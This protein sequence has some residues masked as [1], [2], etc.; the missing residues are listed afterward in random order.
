MADFFARTAESIIGEAIERFKPVRIYAG[1]SGGNDSLA[2]AH[3]V[4]NNV[5]RAELFHVNTG[6]GV[7]QSEPFVRETSERYGWPLTVIRAKE[8]CGQDYDAIVRKHGFPGPYSHQFMYRRLKERAIELLVRRS[9]THRMD[10]V[11]LATGIRED[12]SLKRAGYKGG[13]INRNGAQVWVNPIYWWSKSE[14]DEYLMVNQI[15]RNPVSDTIGISGECLC[16][17]YA[18]PGELE[19]VRTVDPDV[20]ARIDRLHA[21]TKHRF[22]WDWEGRPPSTENKRPSQV[23]AMCIGCEKSAIVQEAML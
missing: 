19:K 16:G 10:K 17:A 9:K 1:F 18:H 2:L 7:K 6:I 5:P 21:E 8:D 3:W 4:M 15:R 20:A 13:E 22:P 14:R 12:E 23:G 11:L